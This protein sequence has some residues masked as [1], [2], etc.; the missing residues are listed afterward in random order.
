[1]SQSRSQINE[2]VVF[3]RLDGCNQVED[4]ARGSRL[5]IPHIRG[6]YA[7]RFAGFPQLKDAA[8]NLVPVVETQ[9]AA[10]RC[11]FSAR[12]RTL[13]PLTESGRV[14]VAYD[15]RARVIEVPLILCVEHA[16]QQPEMGDHAGVRGSCHCGRM[17][18]ARVELIE[19]GE[20]LGHRLRSQKIGSRYGVGDESAQRVA[21]LGM[22]SDENS[23]DIG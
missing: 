1:M 21:E 20:T 13:E 3:R 7:I 23:R 15:F 4:M 14:T 18:E 16:S 19:D 5:I 11:S 17:A 10:H 2:D 6:E 22:T 9:A 12:A 8:Y